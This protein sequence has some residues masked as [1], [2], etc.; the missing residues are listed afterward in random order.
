MEIVPI[1]KQYFNFKL[2]I[3]PIKTEE[4]KIN[5]IIPIK[6]RVATLDIK[7]FG[8]KAYYFTRSSSR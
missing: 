4:H 6:K 2:E 7:D 8:G 3:L 1:K 5:R